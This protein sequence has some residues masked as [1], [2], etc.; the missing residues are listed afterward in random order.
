MKKC[1]YCG[2]Q[3]EDDASECTNCGKGFTEQVP[4][5]SDSAESGK[6]IPSKE[7]QDLR[8]HDIMAVVLIIGGIITVIN[9]LIIV[10]RGAFF[11]DGTVPAQADSSGRFQLYGVMYGLFLIIIG[12][13]HFTARNHFR[14]FKKDSLLLL[15]ALFTAVLA[16]TV[17]YFVADPSAAQGG[18]ADVSSLVAVSGILLYMLYLIIYCRKHKDLFVN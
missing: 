1:H 3:S 14:D 4:C 9:G 7:Q 5:A 6:D 11:K 12:L 2:H 13:F 8:R 16:V 18:L 10:L 17:L 15:T